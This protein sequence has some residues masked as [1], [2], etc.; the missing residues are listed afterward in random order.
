MHLSP[1][2]LGPE[3]CAYVALLVSAPLTERIDPFTS[4]RPR[5]K[6]EMCNGKLTSSDLPLAGRDPH[7]YHPAT[8]TPM[9]RVDPSLAIPDPSEAHYDPWG[10]GDFESS[11]RDWVRGVVTMADTRSMSRLV[12]G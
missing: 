10:Y 3:C 5:R 4:A 7:S 6:E 12:S 2:L 9:H 8:T 11:T 1:G